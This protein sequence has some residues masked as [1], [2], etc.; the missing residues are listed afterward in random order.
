MRAATTDSQAAP[1]ATDVAK[2]SQ[3]LLGANLYLPKA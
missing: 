2:D 1:K 3:A